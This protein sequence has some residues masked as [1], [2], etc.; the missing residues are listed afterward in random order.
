VVND[1][2]CLID[3]YKGDKMNQYQILAICGMLSPIFY[4]LMWIIGGKLKSDYSHIKHDIS[5]LFA[6]G[7][8]NKKLMQFFIIASSVLLF[9]FYLGLNDGLSDGGSTIGP[10]LFIIASILGMLIA[11]FFPLDEGGEMTTWRG[12]MHLIL[13]ILMGILT[14]GGMIALWFRLKDVSGW[15]AF[16]T[17]SLV[18]AIV[19]L[20]LLIISGIFIES[21]YRGLLERLGVTPFQLFYF[22][23][24]LMIFLNN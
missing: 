4:T 7:A 23:L 15:S 18:S 3:V 5:S 13:V 8:P 1:S 21:N 16:A 22:V 24:P 10:Y 9:V 19:A 11:F 17:Y 14:I 2:R 6:V 12:K 20:I